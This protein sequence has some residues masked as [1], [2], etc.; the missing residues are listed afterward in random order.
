MGGVVDEDEAEGKMM[1]DG[2]Q[3]VRLRVYTWLKS[4]GR[5]RRYRDEERKGLN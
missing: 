4:S 1:V 2:D 5:G 3:E